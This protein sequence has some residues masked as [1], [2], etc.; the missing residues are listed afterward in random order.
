MVPVFDGTV[1]CWY[2]CLLA[3][4]FFGPFVVGRVCLYRLFV[5]RFCLVRFFVGTVVCWP[6]CFSWS[7]LTG[8]EF[9]LPGTPPTS[10]S[11]RPELSKFKFL[12]DKKSTHTFLLGELFYYV[13]T[14]GSRANVAHS[15]VDNYLLGK[16]IPHIHPP[17]TF[18]N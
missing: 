17:R 8:R 2:R 18:E 1:F 7:V 15:R 16:L 6:G 11:P 13:K 3:L 9:L 4:G 5:Y 12:K 10:N 14:F